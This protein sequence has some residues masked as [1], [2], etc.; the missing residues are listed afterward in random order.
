LPEKSPCL[1]GLFFLKEAVN[2]GLCTFKEEKKSSVTFHLAWT[3]LA[4]HVYDFAFS[5]VFWI[6]LY[7]STFIK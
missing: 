7:Q 3:L 1:K 4:E 2:S 5:N 6:I